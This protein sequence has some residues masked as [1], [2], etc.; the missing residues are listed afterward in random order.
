MPAKKPTSNKKTVDI[1]AIINTC[2]A[3]GVVSFKYRNIEICFY[4]PK[5]VIINEALP[6][7]LPQYKPMER[8][9]EEEL[10][11]LMVADPLAFEEEYQRD[12]DE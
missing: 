10:A 7:P 8:T 2:K 6:N 5:G 1:L 11:E 12:I 3:A 9:R 4:A